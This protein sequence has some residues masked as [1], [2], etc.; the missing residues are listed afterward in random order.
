MKSLSCFWAMLGLV[1][2]GPGRGQ[3]AREEIPEL[4][5]EIEVEAEKERPAKVDEVMPEETAPMVNVQSFGDVAERQPGVE[6][7]QGGAV[8]APFISL[9]GTNYK[10]TQILVD[11]VPVNPLG[12]PFLNLIPVTAVQKTELVKGPTPPQYPGNTVSGVVN[13]TTKTG[14]EYPGGNVALTFGR[15]DQ[16]V[17][18]LSA[19]GGDA[20]QNYFFAFN[21][22]Y[23]HG[24]KPLALTNM[25]DATMKLVFTPDEQSKLTVVGSFLGGEK[26]GFIAEG[27]NPAGQ[28]AV[29]QRDISRPAGSITYTRQLDPRSDLLVRIAP[30]AFS[31]QTEMQQWNKQQKVVQ[32]MFL[33]QRYELLRSEVQ[34]NTRP[35]PESIVTGGVWYEEDQLRFTSTLSTANLG[36]V[37]ADQWHDYLQQWRGVFG[38]GTWKPKEETA[39]TLGL[40]Y[41]DADPGGDQMTPFFSVHQRT[42][43]TTGVRF[44]VSRT[45]RFPNLHELHGE[46]MWIGNPALE[47]ERGWNYQVDVDKI[48]PEDIQAGCSLY[49]TDLENVIV[50]D[51]NNQYQNVGQARTYGA[52]LE[53]NG[54]LRPGGKWWFNYTYLDAKDETNNRPLITELRTAP[55]KHSAKAGVSLPGEREGL[56]Y[57]GEILFYGSRRTDRSTAGLET[58][59]ALGQQVMVPTKVGSYFLLNAKVRQELGQNQAVTL[60]IQ[61]LLDEDYQN[62]LFYPGPGRWISVGF[63]QG[64]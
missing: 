2:M 48:L 4:E 24:W 15:Y 6:M 52:E 5:I 12:R 53:L 41:D 17:Y 22:T 19:G 30:F 36:N 35:T 63:E 58:Y 31:C 27:P 38:Q 43:P 64:F 11:G 32:P 45:R 33:L 60:S 56:T 20:A 44:A 34:Y 47:A 25:N 50:A 3:Q 13:L 9:R 8:G 1:L 59:P 23:Q 40:R 28:W 29:H 14:D 55:A 10:W 18:E 7:R 37:P 54:R 62:I 57:S 46:G 16:Q 42:D 49:Y 39:L 26:A 21:R 51:A 61:N